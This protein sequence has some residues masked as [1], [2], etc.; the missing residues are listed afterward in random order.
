VYLAVGTINPSNKNLA[1]LQIHINPLVTWI[2]IGCLVLIGGSVVCMW[3]QLELGESRV[4]SGARGVAAT[5][6]SVVLG[7]ML[8]ATPAAR[9]QTMPGMADTNTGTV[10]IESDV[11]RSVFGALRCMCGTCARD[12]L[13]TCTCE[14]AE[15][16]RQKI[17]AKLIAGETRDEIVSEYSAQYGLESLAVPPNRGIFR[18]IWAIPLVAIAL[19]ALALGRLMRRWRAG[20]Q[21]VTGAAPAVAT[22]R[23]AYDARLD[24]ELEDLE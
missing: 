5:A 8:A 22:P 4:W 17:R 15:E 10:H 20:P 18:A 1:S 6:A 3:P 12:L 24:D 14:T 2:W 21:P 7:I 16:A 19:G 23:D 13:S 11:E 9:A